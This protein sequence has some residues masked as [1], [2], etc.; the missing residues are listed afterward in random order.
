MRHRTIHVI[1]F[2][3]GAALLAACR[4]PFTD[5]K[6]DPTPSSGIW[7]GY[8]SA[9]ATT[10]G[11]RVTNQTERPVSYAAFEQQTA[12]VVLFLACAGGPQC[13]SLAPG[14]TRVLPWSDVGGYDPSRNR[15]VLYWWQIVTEPDGT[16]HGGTMQTV[17]VT[18]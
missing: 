17:T 7:A 12:G 13:P 3:A 15:F 4:Q 14:A 5:P 11:I 18:R 6:I 10:A 2:L 9:T 8:V 16:V 1:T